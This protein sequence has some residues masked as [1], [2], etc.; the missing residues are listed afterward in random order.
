MSSK[1]IPTPPLEKKYE[2]ISADIISRQQALDEAKAD[3][4]SV[5]KVIAVNHD[6]QD[7]LEENKHYLPPVEPITPF[8]E[9]KI[10]GEPETSRR[11][12]PPS[13]S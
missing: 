10:F 2:E 12:G 3:L 9:T 1:A 11:E 13:S 7:L 4:E 6:K 8:T 5:R